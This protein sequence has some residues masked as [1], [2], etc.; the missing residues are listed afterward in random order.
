MVHFMFITLVSSYVAP[1]H[2]YVLVCNLY[3]T[4]SFFQLVSGRNS[5]NPA[6]L[7]V[8]GA[9]GIFSSGPPQRAES[10]ELI[11]FR[12]R[13]GGNRQSFAVFTLP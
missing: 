8:L 7:L 13:I 3:I 2:S 9:G 6:I 10:V 5:T 12:E 11:D 1:M 4:L